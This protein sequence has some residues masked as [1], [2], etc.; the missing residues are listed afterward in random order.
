MFGR[1]QTQAGVLLELRPDAAFAP[2]DEA[3][4]TAFRNK[5]WYASSVISS[6]FATNTPLKALRRG[7]QQAG[8]SVRED[9]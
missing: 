1:G 2:N 5:V 7:S 8:A 3:A 6:A 9:L 4:L